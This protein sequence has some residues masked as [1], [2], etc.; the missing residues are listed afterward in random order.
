MYWRPIKPRVVLLAESHVY[1]TPAELD[2]Q[3]QPLPE[4]PTDLPRGF[5][6]LVYALGYGENEL[7]DQAIV[8]PRNSGTPQYWKIFQSCL[9]PIGQVAD[10]STMQ[11]SRTPDARSRLRAK[12]GVLRALKDRGV[13]LLDASVAALYLPGRPK[14]AAEIRSAVLQASWDQ[15]VRAVL[16]EAAPAAVLCVGVGVARALQSRLQQTD[17]PWAAVPQPQAHLSSQGHAAIHAIYSRVCS[18]A[19]TIGSV[20]PVV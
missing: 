4:L 13:W 9:T 5:V 10:C 1:T 8:S 12:L 6:R 7:L 18:D 17:I 15:Y 3:L 19:S 20:P 14:P 2:R 11:A 16:L